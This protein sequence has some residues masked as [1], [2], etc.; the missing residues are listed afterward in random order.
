LSRLEN[1]PVPISYPQAHED[2]RVVFFCGAGISFPAGLPGFRGLVDKLYARLGATP[3]PAEKAAIKRGQFDTAIGLLEQD[4]PG[5]RAAVRPHIA[6]ILTPNFSKPQAIVTHEALLTLGRSREGR[7]RLIT[8]NFDRLFAEVI[9]RR[10]LPLHTFEAPLL[11][12]PKNRWD[13]LVYLHGVLTATPTPSDLDRLVVSSGDFGLAYLTERWAARFVTDLFHNYLVCFVG[14]SI[15]DPVLRYMMDALAADRLLGEAPPEMFA[16]GSYSKGKQ[17]ERANE[18]KAKNVAPILYREH[19]GHA[20]LHRTLR[21]WAETYRDGVLGKERIVTQYATAKPLSST[22][23]DDFVG[24]MLW[25]LSDQRALPAKRF[26]DFDPVPS[27]EWLEPLSETR[28]RYDDLARFG[29]TP[30]SKVDDKLTYSLVRR[31]APYSHAPWMALVA[32]GH[33]EAS[34]WDNVMLHL[35]R[36]LTR[37]LGD[38]KLMLWLAKWGGLLNY[39]FGRLITDALA[40]NPPS[41][42]MNTLWAVTLAG[43]LRIYATH[44]NL[45]DWGEHLKRNGLTA[46][47]RLQL[48]DLLSPRVRLR[49]PFLMRGGHGQDAIGAPTRVKDL[50]DWEIVLGTDHVHSTL[51]DLAKNAPWQEALS[52]LLSDATGLLRDALDLMRELGGIEDRHDSSYIHQPSISDHPQNRDYRDWTALIDIARDSWVATAARF[53]E[54]AQLEVQRWMAM[55]YPLFRRLVFFAATDTSLFQ[56][57]QAL[58]WLLM[59]EHWGYGQWR[60]NARPYACWSQSRHN[61]MR[62]AEKSWSRPS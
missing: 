5:R 60:H 12:V 1:Q 35:A 28:F 33:S 6:E 47:L 23:Q 41:A 2:G 26:A 13:G 16:F 36:W 20:F 19:R 7:Y 44:S 58:E 53:P 52:E 45:Y 9:A 24:R 34:Q 37:H 46:T 32:G 59:D 27:L 38:P 54:R 18:W 43:R 49:E 14:Y 21:A 55:P 22:T 11:P 50:V 8:T 48:R 17:A 25:A 29:V 57:R 15:N 4:Y 51:R 39:Q 42:P 61:W 62:K 56:S 30:N 40:K 3:S 31:P 10:A